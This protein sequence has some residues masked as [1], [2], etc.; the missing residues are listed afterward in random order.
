[1]TYY[2]WI[3][4]LHIIAIVAWMA[5]AFYLP[6]LLVYHTE[7][8]DSSDFVKVVQIQ[9]Y[10]L[11]HYITKP[12]MWVSVL[13]GLWLLYINPSLLQQGFMHTK[14]LALLILIIYTLSLNRFILSL[15]EGR[16][17]KSGRFFRLYNE[18]PTVLL[19]IIVIMVVVKPF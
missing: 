14:L 16:C 15:K 13:S 8:K 9:E 5:G 6:R 2:L 11:Y 1:M 4:A 10:K 18:V 19:I 17:Q 7:Y 3:K 12:A